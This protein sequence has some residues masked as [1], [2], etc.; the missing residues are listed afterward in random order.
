MAAALDLN[1]ARTR[2]DLPAVHRCTELD[3]EFHT[4]VAE[5]ARNKALLLTRE[6]VGLLLYPHSR[7]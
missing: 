1:L 2:H 7:F 6:A 5:G 4:L 3:T